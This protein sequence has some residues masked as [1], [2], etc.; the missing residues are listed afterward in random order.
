MK[1]QLSPGNYGKDCLG[2]GKHFDN[3]GEL[4]ECECDECNFML[5]CIDKNFKGKTLTEKEADELHFS[6]K[7]IN[8]V[9]NR[10]SSIIPP[11][12]YFDELEKYEE[13]T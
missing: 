9:F 8:E 2:N 12:K 13:E 7:Y 11:L 10:F 5:L 3:K 6:L 4:I 1:I